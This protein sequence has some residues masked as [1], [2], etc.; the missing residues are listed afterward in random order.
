M[1]YKKIQ[2]L[3]TPEEIISA[4][5]F[6]KNLKAL[7][8]T[9]DREIRSIIENKSDKFLL[10][11]GPCSA[12]EER[13][14][15]EYVSRLARVQ[16]RVKEKIVII[17]RIYTNKPRTTGDGYMGMLHQPDPERGP[18]IAAGIAS[19][20]RMH[21]RAIA[22]SGLTAADEMLYPDNNVYVE[23]LLSYITIGARSTEN[24]QHRL[25]ASGASQP[26]GIKNPTN[27]DLD[28]MFNSI[29][30]VQCSHN[31]VY[32]GYEVETDGNPLA[33]GILRGSENRGEYIP[34]YHFED[35]IR[36]YE[37]YTKRKLLN[38]MLIIDT[39]HANS[40]KLFE[41]QPRIASE[42]LHSRRHSAVLALLVRGLMIESFIEEGSQ[43][44]GGCVYGKS[45]TDGCIGWKDTEKLIYHIAENVGV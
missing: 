9:K 41:E 24:Q 22:E 35:L 6:P 31:F 18:N 7:K 17:P 25:A 10:I 15:C 30:A 19:I 5:P 37:S 43:A 28:V 34:N 42:I 2:K 11:I 12:S 21:I 4:V 8:D 20:R 27:G 45:I 16:E 40:K 36:A 39:N 44:V 32:H 26:V 38:P 13:C 14:V 3:P 29:Y 1:S 33:H 23:D